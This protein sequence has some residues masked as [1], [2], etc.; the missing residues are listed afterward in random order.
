MINLKS[1]PAPGKI[2]WGVLESIVVDE[3]SAEIQGRAATGS[4]IWPRRPS[5]SPLRH[6]FIGRSS[7]V[8]SNWLITT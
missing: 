5:N 4:L 7:P 3:I 2:D 8:I 6:R 1:T